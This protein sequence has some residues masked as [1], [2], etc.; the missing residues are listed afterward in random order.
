MLVVDAAIKEARLFAAKDEDH[1][2]DDSLG[3]SARCVREV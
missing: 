3:C 1:I 2:V